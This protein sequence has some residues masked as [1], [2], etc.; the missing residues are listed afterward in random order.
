M[1]HLSLELK[2]VFLQ[3]ISFPPGPLILLKYQNYL[4]SVQEMILKVGYF[5]LLELL[6]YTLKEQKF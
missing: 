2:W 4:I 1:V 3:R 6:K 5:V